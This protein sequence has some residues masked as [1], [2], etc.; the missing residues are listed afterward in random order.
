MK[1]SSLLL[2]LGQALLFF[3]AIVLGYW[4][5]TPWTGLAGVGLIGV[6]S[7]WV[8]ARK[9]AARPG[10]RWPLVA[11]AVGTVLVLATPFFQRGRPFTLDLYQT[12]VVWLVALAILPVSWFKR[13]PS[14]T[15]WKILVLSWALLGGFLWLAAAY[16]ANLQGLFYLSLLPN[17]IFLCLCKKVFALPVWA[18]QAINTLLLVLIALPTVDFITRPKYRLDLELETAARYFSYE[19]ARKDPSAFQY[20]WNRYYTREW[21]SLSQQVFMPDPAGKLPFRLRPSSEGHFFK[22]RMRINSAGF[23]GAEIGEKGAAYRIVALGESSTYGITL[24]AD[25]KPWPEVLQQKIEQC[26]KPNRPVQVIN[27]GVPAYNLGDNVSRLESDILPAKPDMIISY[28]GFNGF[29]LLDSSVP[30]ATGPL[31]PAYK[32]RAVK[33]LAD[34]EHRV[35][36]FW[37]NRTRTSRLRRR[38]PTFSN[39]SASRCAAAYRGLIAFAQTNKIRLVL[40]DFAMAVNGHSDPDVIEFYRSTFPSLYWQMRANPV[41]TQLLKEL[42]RENPQVLFVDIQTQLDGEHSKF[43]DLM[44]PSQEGNQQLAD[45]IFQG[46]KEW[47]KADLVHQ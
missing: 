16:V 10:W 41:Q 46:I 1:I 20:W 32:E 25:D 22:S 38:A 44:H 47:L 37:Y 11:S 29:G 13:E 36:V 42:A 18:T 43:I 2:R 35:R 39:P 40:C 33:L 7:V 30:D 9:E 6:S 26:L 24:N 8:S 17:I 34:L 21:S 45:N 28:H 5:Q 4:V 31:P 27:A 19:T 12:V 3:A 23:R 14:N 15:G